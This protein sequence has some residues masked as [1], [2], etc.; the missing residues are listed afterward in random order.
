MKVNVK[1]KSGENNAVLLEDEGGNEQWMPLAD[2]VKMQYVSIGKAE[3]TITDELVTYLKMEKKTPKAGP[4]F[5]KPQKTFGSN[6]EKPV[7][8]KPTEPEE[9]KKFY[10]TKHIVLEGLSGEELRAGLDAASAHNWVIA[11]QTHFIDGKWYAVI[12]YKVKPE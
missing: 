5:G 10:K 9:E 6:F 1:G 4:T 2:N 7:E 8:K 12:Y 11:T 3:V